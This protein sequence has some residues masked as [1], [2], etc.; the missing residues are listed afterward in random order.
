MMKKILCLCLMALSLLACN[1]KEETSLT[2]TNPYNEAVSGTCELCSAPDWT[3]ATDQT[4][5]QMGIIIDQYGVPTRMQEGDLIGAFVGESCRGRAEAFLDSEG[6][7][8]INLTVHAVSTDADLS[9]MQVVLKYYSTRE[10]GMYT[11]QPI[12][13]ED[14]AIL[15]TNLKGYVPAWK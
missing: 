9:K 14:D 12:A 4:L 13:Y 5:S 11:S 15:G 1:K 8:R 3:V 7:W 2:T 10:K 6:K